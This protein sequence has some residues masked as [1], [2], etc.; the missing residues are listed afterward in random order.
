MKLNYDK[1]CKYKNKILKF[2]NIS[3]YEQKNNTLIL[4][5]SILYRNISYIELSK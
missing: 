2:K 4:H 3:E 5:L 1:I